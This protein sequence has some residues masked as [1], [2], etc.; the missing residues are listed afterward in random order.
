MAKF[1]TIG[2]RLSVTAPTV[3]KHS[4]QEMKSQF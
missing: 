1:V 2:E 3:T 4:Q